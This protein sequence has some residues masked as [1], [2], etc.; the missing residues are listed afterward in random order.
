LK[1]VTYPQR[2]FSPFDARLKVD[3]GAPPPNEGDKTDFRLYNSAV[4]ESI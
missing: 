2:S 4:C 3:V 1:S